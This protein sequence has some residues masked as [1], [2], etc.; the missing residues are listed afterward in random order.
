MSPTEEEIRA[1][2]AREWGRRPPVG[3]STAIVFSDAFSGVQLLLDGIWDV[4]DMRE[5]EVHELNL[6]TAAA[7][8][9]IRDR[10]Q[11]EV[12]DALVQAGIAFA[13][14]HP[15]APRLSRRVEMDR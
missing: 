1:G 3:V 11:R 7:I 14:D 15:D 5:S 4:E 9:P 12:F 10:V 8:R 2:I 13:A 6:L